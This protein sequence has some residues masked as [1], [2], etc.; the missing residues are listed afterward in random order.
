MLRSRLR[1]C[2]FRTFDIPE[3]G[4]GLGIVVGVDIQVLGPNDYYQWKTT[5]LGS[6]RGYLV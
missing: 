3:A 4:V 5:K 6:G 1:L 2:I